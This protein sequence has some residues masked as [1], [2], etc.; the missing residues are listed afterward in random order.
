MLWG[1]GDTVKDPL[2]S[3]FDKAMQTNGTVKSQ[4]PKKDSLINHYKKLI[5]L[6]RA[7]PEIARGTIHALDF[8]QYVFFSG[9]ISDYRDSKAGVFHNT[10]EDQIT[11]DLKDYTDS[12]FSVVRG[13]AGKGSATLNGTILTLS[14]FTS[15]VVK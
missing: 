13:Y 1:D 12:D 9:F 10:G 5:R 2:G 3:T 6:R 15:V 7:N 8:S 4:L 14:G 11:V